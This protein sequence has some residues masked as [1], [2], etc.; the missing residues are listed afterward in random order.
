MS[1]NEKPETDLIRFA[2]H[3]TAQQV[4]ERVV[5]KSAALFLDTVGC[6]YGGSSAE[7]IR[8][9]IDIAEVWGGK[10]QA[11][12]FVHNVM[13]SAPQAA[14]ANGVMI[15]ARDYDDTHDTAVN[16]GCVTIVPAMVAAVQLL[17]GASE[18]TSQPSEPERSGKTDQT[19]PIRAANRTPD[20]ST[21]YTGSPGKTRVPKMVSGLD[22]LASMAVALDVAN[23][24]SLSLIPYLSVGWLP[25]TIAGPFGAACGVGRLLGLNEQQMQHAF[26]FAYAQVHGNRQAL[27]EGTLAKRMQPAFSAVAGINAA[28]FA[29]Q[30]LTAAADIISGPYGLPALYTDGRYDQGPLVDGLGADWETEQISIKPYPSCRCTHPVIDAALT[31]KQERH[32]CA[33]DIVKG[34]ISIPPTSMGQI[35]F[36]FAVRENPT[37]DAQFSAQ[38]TAALT[39]LSGRPT[40]KDFE[41][42]TVRS[43]TDVAELA[44]ELE[45]I[46]FEKER[47]GLT[48][49]EIRLQLKDTTEV[50]CRIS[51]P[52]G[53][54]EHPLT[55]EQL[56]EKL[57]DNLSYAAYPP[58][59]KQQQEIIDTLLSVQSIGDMTTI[60]ER[61]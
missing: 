54:P 11:R 8:E 53:S 46:E 52:L 43:R 10:P 59:E 23:R 22:F 12:I 7:S 48:P 27:V 61:L 21:D 18:N 28:M 42:S 39:F 26:G 37:V 35:G 13:T 3:T 17:S 36:P 19:G 16:H 32:V 6:L 38:Y 24:I 33:D 20:G 31:L 30:G 55:E 1:C 5:K 45:V 47:T 25:T 41:A 49:V 15:H 60:L 40:L 44:K 51:T 14:F 56:V 29:S 4:P 58:A 34:T 50:H 57:K 9:I 2:A